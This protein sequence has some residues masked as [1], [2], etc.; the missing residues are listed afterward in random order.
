VGA[1]TDPDEAVATRVAVTSLYGARTRRGLVSLV[2]G[3]H[4]VIVPP[5]KAREIAGMLFECAEAA[6]GDAFLVAWAT[7]AGMTDRE[8][9]GLLLAFRAHRERQRASG[10]E[11]E[12]GN[13]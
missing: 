13:G 4:Q 8:A 9:G 7:G 2:V 3:E 10:R 5:A 1:L 11:G 12:D 6:E